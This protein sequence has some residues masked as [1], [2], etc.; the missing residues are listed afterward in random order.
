[1]KYRSS[2]QTVKKKQLDSA[3]GLS[4]SAFLELEGIQICLFE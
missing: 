2:V 4:L 3:Q 1:M